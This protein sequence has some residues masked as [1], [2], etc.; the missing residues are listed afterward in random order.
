MIVNR[1]CI[2]SFGTITF[3]LL[4][5]A[6]ATSK[7]EPGTVTAKLRN[8]SAAN[9]IDMRSFFIHYQNNRRNL[10][11]PYEGSSLSAYDLGFGILQNKG[12]TSQYT[13]EGDQFIATFGRL[14]SPNNYLGIFLGP[15]ILTDTSKDKENIT[16]HT[17]MAKGLNYEY[18]QDS[19]QLSF[20]FKND[21]MYANLFLPAGIEER[22]VENRFALSTKYKFLEILEASAS[23]SYSFLNDNNEFSTF[24]TGLT[25]EYVLH[26]L[27]F[28]GGVGINYGQSKFT[29]SRYPSPW[30]IFG[31]GPHA[32]AHYIARDGL[33]ISCGYAYTRF[34]DDLKIDGYET[35]RF[36][37]VEFGDRNTLEFQLSYVKMNSVSLGEEWYDNQIS[38]NL[39][40]SI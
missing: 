39:T 8:D 9:K 25:G 1:F 5:I 34:V 26:P 32:G 2:L 30:Y 35:N 37:Q 13:F 18:T 36:I 3:F 23:I 17:L 6:L 19:F 4:S 38:L 29:T 7:E 40:Y 28:F 27:S 21:Y 14:F 31:A 10:F 24:Q 20:D 22:L 16:E 11:W 33:A 15:H 12:N